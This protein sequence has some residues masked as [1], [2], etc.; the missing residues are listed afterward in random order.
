MTRH[1]GIPNADRPANNCDAVARM[2]R[3]ERTICGHSRC[4][5]CPINRNRRE[6][7]SGR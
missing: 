2:M 3:G 4:A 1:R 7:D 6:A 5:N